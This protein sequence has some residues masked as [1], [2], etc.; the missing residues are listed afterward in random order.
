MDREG[1]N[2]VLAFLLGIVTGG[3]T[4]LLL[5]PSSGSET[6]K[7]LSEGAKR[8]RD[9]AGRLANET[10]DRI[11][12]GV[13]QAKDFAETQKSAVQDFAETKKSAIREALSEGKA[14]YQRESNRDEEDES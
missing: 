13:E 6:R 7:K 5:A 12:Q 2:T 4:A 9:E 3:V 1:S 8:L 14:A 10:G 11:H